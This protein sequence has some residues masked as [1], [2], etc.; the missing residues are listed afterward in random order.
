[1]MDGVTHSQYKKE[2]YS[3]DTL[4][5]GQLLRIK[6]TKEKIYYFYPNL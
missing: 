1:M 6:Q 4:K 3:V 2:V 5:K